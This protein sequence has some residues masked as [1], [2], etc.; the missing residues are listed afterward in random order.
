MS[1]AKTDVFLDS[2]VIIAGLA[3]SK[4]S[5]YMILALA[6]MGVIQPGISDNTPGLPICT[7]GKFLELFL[8]RIYQ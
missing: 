2:S 1:I 5:S 6:E 7:P 4:G 3:S 8:S